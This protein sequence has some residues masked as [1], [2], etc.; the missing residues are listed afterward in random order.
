[1]ALRCPLC[2][3]IYVNRATLIEHVKNV[4][5]I[6]RAQEFLD[7]IQMYEKTI[8]INS[9]VHWR[10]IKF[11][12]HQCKFTTHLKSVMLMHRS[13]KGH[14]STPIKTRQMRVLLQQPQI[15]PIPPTKKVETQVSQQ[16]SN[17]GDWPTF[18][19]LLMPMEK[20]PTSPP[21]QFKSGNLVNAEKHGSPSPQFK[22]GNLSPSPQFKPGNSV[23]A[24]MHGSP[25][26]QF[27]PGN[28]SPSP[29]FKPGNLVNAKMHGYPYWPGLIFREASSGEFFDSTDKK[30]YVKFFDVSKTTSAWVCSSS[31]TSYNSESPLSQSENVIPLIRYR[32][33][34]AIE[35]AVYAEDWDDEDRLEY[36]QD[37]K[38]KK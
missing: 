18:P 14:D 31:V 36:F 37:A 6:E 15:Q 19:T 7:S 1:M 17:E 35:W 24:K 25:S 26:P 23:N 8:K 33:E 28:L 34:K 3:D 22:T 10:C 30:Y 12:C 29:Q 9:S 16:V 27:K 21:P 13:R 32:M 20:P 5:I 38:K 2:Q 11:F 4:H